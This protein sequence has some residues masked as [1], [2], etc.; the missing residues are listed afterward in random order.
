MDIPAWPGQVRRA[1]GIVASEVLTG[2]L[3]VPGRAYCGMTGRM[4]LDGRAGSW[5][6]VCRAGFSVVSA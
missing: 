5:K 3:R 2:L 1:A 4:T 6:T